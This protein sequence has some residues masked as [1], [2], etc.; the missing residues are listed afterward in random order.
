M[1]F[2]GTSSSSRV[3]ASTSFR[4]TFKVGYETEMGQSLCV[5][6]SIPELGQWKQFK[7]HM[8]WT[9]GHVW[10]LENQQ[11]NAPYFQYKYVVLN[12]GQPD[13]W[14]KGINRIGDM[15]L[16]Q[17][18]TG[19]GTDLSIYDQFDRYTV[20]FS[21]HYPMEDC[22]FMRINGDP[23]E[24]GLWNKLEGPLKMQRARN[25]VVWLTG[26]KVKPWEFHCTFKQG[27]CP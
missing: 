8:K 13:R 23:P 6:G 1:G 10:V 15:V 7:A 26:E 20:N 9:S 11:I 12:N 2:S 17:A 4:C 14:E 18:Q 22:E 5:V 25:E 16:L 19:G 21:M 3:P 24:L 27:V